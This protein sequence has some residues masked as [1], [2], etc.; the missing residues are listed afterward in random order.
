MTKVLN[1]YIHFDGRRE[2]TRGKAVSL[3]HRLEQ[4]PVHG[5]SCPTVTVT[6]F[7]LNKLFKSS[8]F[9]QIFEDLAPYCVK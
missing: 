2:S 7:G 6:G 1:P 9:H 5:E 8:Y 4:G 3:S